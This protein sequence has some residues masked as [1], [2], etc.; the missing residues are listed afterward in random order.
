MQLLNFYV[1]TKISCK[2]LLNKSE[3]VKIKSKMKEK[4]NTIVP[5]QLFFNE[6]GIAKIEIG[7]RQVT[8]I[9]LVKIAK[10]LNVTVTWLLGGE[11]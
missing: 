10:A 3:I 4:G 1:H 11:K 2:L 8:D 9:E 5:I 7:V 6:R